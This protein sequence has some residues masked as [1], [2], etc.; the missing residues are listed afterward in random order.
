MNTVEITSIGIMLPWITFHILPSVGAFLMIKT[1]C[2]VHT[3]P[4]QK[5]IREGRSIQRFV[6]V[7][8]GWE[9]FVEVQYFWDAPSILTNAEWKKSALVQKKVGGE[10]RE[11][12]RERERERDVRV[13]LIPVD[14]F[15]MPSFFLWLS[16]ESS[17]TSSINTAQPPFTHTHTHTVEHKTR[18]FAL[19]MVGWAE[20]YT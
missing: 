13:K 20:Y 12:E 11:G 19:N 17:L 7:R 16:S 8:A 1:D 15:G 3:I 14:P 10:K 4:E 2:A 6:C 5:M 18:M 9:S